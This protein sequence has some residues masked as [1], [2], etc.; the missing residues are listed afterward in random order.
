MNIPNLDYN[1]ASLSTQKVSM[2]TYPLVL[3]FVL[4]IF[5]KFQY[6]VGLAGVIA[7]IAL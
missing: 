6:G 5:N 2:I 7:S 1:S 4:T 3:F